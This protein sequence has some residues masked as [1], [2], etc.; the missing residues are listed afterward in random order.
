MHFRVS[1]R[2]FHA[3]NQAGGSGYYQQDSGCKK[4][5]AAACL[6]YFQRFSSYLVQVV[7]NTKKTSLITHSL[8][9]NCNQGNHCG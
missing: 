9:H 7:S 4:I 6:V 3:F 8:L 5:R 2:N 1:V